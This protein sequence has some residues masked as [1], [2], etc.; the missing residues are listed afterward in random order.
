MVK[1]TKTIFLLDILSIFNRDLPLGS[2]KKLK[3]VRKVIVINC[4]LPR[5]PILTKF[6]N[7]KNRKIP[8]MNN[9]NFIISMSS[10]LDISLIDIEVRIINKIRLIL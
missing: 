1:N 7:I 4:K 2:S 8:V 6:V 10:M 5:V 3:V 9:E